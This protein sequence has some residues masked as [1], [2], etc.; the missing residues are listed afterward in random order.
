M[1]DDHSFFYV[2]K[3]RPKKGTRLVFKF[4]RGSDEFK[5]QKVYLLRFNFVSPHQSKAVYGIF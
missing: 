3:S 5:M 2:Q 4:C 1:L